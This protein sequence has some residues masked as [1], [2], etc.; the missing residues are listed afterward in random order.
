MAPIPINILPSVHQFFSNILPTHYLVDGMRSLI[1]Y[2]GRMASG[3]SSALITLSIFFV[4]SVVLCY[5]ISQ[6]K[7]NKDNRNQSE[8]TTAE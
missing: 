6:V 4:V 1:Y 8:V 7:F 3:M 2:D 5:I